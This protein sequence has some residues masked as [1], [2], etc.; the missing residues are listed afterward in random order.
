MQVELHPS[1]SSVFPSSQA[2]KIVA[3]SD[4]RM[5]FPQTGSGTM[6]IPEHP[7]ISIWLSVPKSQVS[8]RLSVEPPV[9]FGS[10]PK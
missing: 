9:I 1:P 8:S 4:S 7:Q 5:P 2:S 3:P 10:V 6:S